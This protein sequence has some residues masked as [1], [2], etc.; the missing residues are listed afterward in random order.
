[1]GSRGSST[2]RNKDPSCRVYEEIS[3]GDRELVIREPCSQKDYRELM[4]VQIKIWG[5]N[6]V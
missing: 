1:M 3:I 6:Y 4:E 5:R 2:L